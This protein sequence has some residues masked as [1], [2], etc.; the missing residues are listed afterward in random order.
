MRADH[1]AFIVETKVLKMSWAE[2]TREA[3]RPGTDRSWYVGLQGEYPKMTASDLMAFAMVAGE[4]MTGEEIDPEDVDGDGVRAL[5]NEDQPL[6]GAMLKTVTFTKKGKT[7]TK[8]KWL[9]PSAAE[10]TE[11]T[12]IAVKL[13][14]IEEPKKKAAAGK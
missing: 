2:G 5:A 7:F 14:L 13:G 4:A 12:A 6:T 11:G 1:T 3:I 8:H 9:V 10:K